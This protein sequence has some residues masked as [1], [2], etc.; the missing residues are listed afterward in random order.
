[1][2]FKD[3]KFKKRITGGVNGTIHFDNGLIL[4]AAAGKMAY[5]TPRE[6]LNSEDKFSSFEL[7]VL[8]EDHIPFFTRLVL[9]DHDDDVMGWVGR[10]KINDIINSINNISEEAILEFINNR[11]DTLDD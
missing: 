4:S 1:M 9:P 8:H 11:K 10:D 2:E 6:D 7:A 5:S 3:L